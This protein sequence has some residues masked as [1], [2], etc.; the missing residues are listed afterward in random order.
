MGAELKTGFFIGLGI[1]AALAAL[2]LVM[3]AVGGSGGRG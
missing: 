1:V 3:R 2:G